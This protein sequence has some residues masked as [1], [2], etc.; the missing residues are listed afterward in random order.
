MGN[1]NILKMTRPG[2]WGF[3]LNW[4]I[5]ILV[6]T[7]LCME[8]QKGPRFET[9]SKRGIRWASKRL[10][11]DQR[12]NL[13]PWHWIIPSLVCQPHGTSQG[14]LPS[15]YRGERW[16][17]ALWWL[18][19]EG[20]VLS[21]KLCHLVEAQRANPWFSLVLFFFSFL[22]I[23]PHSYAVCVGFLFILVFRVFWTPAMQHSKFLVPW[24]GI[25]LVPPAVEAQSLNY[26]T[27]RETPWVFFLKN[28][29]KECTYLYNWIAWLCGILIE[30]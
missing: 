19:L 1:P 12:E 30:V 11:L 14:L 8:R 23:Y 20:L 9:W 25:K 28:V 10:R 2:G 15:P 21:Q 13:A 22:C 16:P 26:C 29:H 3:W 7:G 27:N 24:L 17:P 5:M 18:Y 6:R 4:V